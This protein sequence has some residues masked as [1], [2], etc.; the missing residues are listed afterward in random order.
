[1]VLSGYGNPMTL[2]G[3]YFSRAKEEVSHDATEVALATATGDGRPSVR[4]VLL[5]ALDERGLVFFTNYG[6]RKAQELVQ[7]PHAAM[8]FL[9][10]SL[11]V[12]VRVEGVVE[13]LCDEDSDAYFATRERLSQLGAWASEQSQPLP[14][15]ETLLARVEEVTQR[16]LG[17]E[18]PRPPHW[19]GFLLLPLKMEF[20]QGEP[21]RLHDRLV[22]ARETTER[23]FSQ[24]RL[25]P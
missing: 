23:D 10:P 9:W 17:Q 2:F 4:M 12:Q 19:G 16:F 8:C 5:K 6:S 24:T 20:W 3:V 7:N 21:G 13:K 22:Y 25:Y 18:V 1:M 15:R 14:N 11:Q